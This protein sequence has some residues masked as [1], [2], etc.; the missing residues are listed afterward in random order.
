[1]HGSVSVLPTAN[2]IHSTLCCVMRI[3]L[4]CHVAVYEEKWGHI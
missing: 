4:I 3:T 2:G 1:M